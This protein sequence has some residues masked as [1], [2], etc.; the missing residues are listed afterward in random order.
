[1][2][3]NV[4]H[5]TSLTDANSA[6]DMMDG[7]QSSNEYGDEWWDFLKLDDLASPTDSTSWP[8]CP[9]ELPSLEEASQ[10]PQ[11]LEGACTADNEEDTNTRRFVHVVGDSYLRGNDT[12][13]PPSDIENLLLH[14]SE[15]F[16]ELVAGRDPWLT[17]TVG[18]ED[19]PYSLRCEALEDKIL[20]LADAFDQTFEAT[21]VS[22][23]FTTCHYLC[24]A[25]EEAKFLEWY[26]TY[27]YQHEALQDLVLEAMLF[28][29]FAYVSEEQL[30]RSPFK[31]V[32]EGQHALFRSIQARY[33]VLEQSYSGAVALTQVALILSFWSPYNGSQEVNSFW[34][35]EA[36]RH[37]LIAKLYDGSRPH[38]VE[39]K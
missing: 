1:M 20:D 30:R 14:S 23:Y 12:F 29:A 21:L 15:S 34:V 19:V 6:T 27:T 5:E 33:H 3:D 35:D 4:E 39:I 32:P 9:D 22:L 8:L 18:L 31:S 10:S 24:P 38:D 11:S 7:V 2:A 25:I 36:F 13:S 16:F 28:S 37:A 17:F 26:H